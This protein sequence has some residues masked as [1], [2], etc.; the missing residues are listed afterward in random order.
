[1][2]ISN[3]KTERL[4]FALWPDSKIRQAINEQSQIVTQMTNGKVMPSENWHITLAFLG[5][6]DKPTKNCM[7]KVAATVSDNRFSLSLD[8]LGYWHKSRILWFGANHI[9]EALEN[10]IVHLNTNLQNCGYRPDTRPFHVHLTLMRKVSKL[11]KKTLPPITPIIWTV[12][13]FCLVRSV[14]HS[15]GANYEVIARYLLN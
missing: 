14:T 1:M 2:H 10:L 11:I 9:P 13:D 8:Q 12:D 5:Y 4:F 7:Q 3:H 15:S 6:V